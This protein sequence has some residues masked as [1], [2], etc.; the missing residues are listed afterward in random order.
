M[1]HLVNKS[2]FGSTSL[3][4]CLKFATKGAPILL[5]EDG[6]YGVVAGTALEAKIKDA[7]KDHPVYAL[8]E[9]LMARGIDGV[10]DG[11]KT[12]DYPGFVELVE[13]HKTCT[14]S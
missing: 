10:I 3:E 7:M 8:K 12:V 2:P 9:D 13:Q 11:V 6:I 4:S 5:F 1:L 14:W